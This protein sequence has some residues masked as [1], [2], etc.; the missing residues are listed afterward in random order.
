MKNDPYVDLLRAI[1]RL[2]R[3]DLSS[4]HERLR[5]DAQRFFAPGGGLQQWYERIKNGLI[6]QH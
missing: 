4:R 5:L 3:R 2:A 6:E 1:I